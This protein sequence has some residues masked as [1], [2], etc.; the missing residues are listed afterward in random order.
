M[1]RLWVSTVDDERLA[2]YRN[3]PQA[4][5]APWTTRF[6][7]EGPWLVERLA[8]SEYELESVVV[9]AGH[10][11]RV[12]D[13]VGEEVPVFVLPAAEI[14]QLIGFNF[15]RGM[16]ACGRRRPL[17]QWEE[18]ASRLP[19]GPALLVA[20]IDIQ[21]PTNL[22]SILRSAAA[23]GVA[24]VLLSPRCADPFSRRVLRVSMGTAL[25]LNLI[26]LAEPSRE[27]AAL[28]DPGGWELLAS[29]LEEGAEELDQ[30]RTGP[31]VVLLVGNEAHGLSPD[32][33]ATCQRRVTLRM[34]LG[35]DSLNAATAT[36]V[37][38]YHLTRPATRAGFAD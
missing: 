25:R 7:V 31:R 9:A 29:V 35:T 19:S 30:V 13:T 5:P 28:R 4:N 6:V 32:T 10:E 12:P 8:A 23:F 11:D 27:L 38:L 21:D 37:F 3:L 33:V 2:P 15:H 18:F 24:G 22:G 20:C 17:W 36:A 26:R 1:P 34:S 16:L 14:E